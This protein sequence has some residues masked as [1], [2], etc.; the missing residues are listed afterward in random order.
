MTVALTTPLV[1]LTVP[2]ALNRVLSV[3]PS[4]SA[5]PGNATSVVVNFEQADR[6]NGLSHVVK[7]RQYWVKEDGRWRILYEGTG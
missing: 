7:K 4:I 3:K 2:F 1:C 6:S 5:I